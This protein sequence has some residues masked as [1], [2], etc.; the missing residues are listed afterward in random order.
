MIMEIENES[1]AQKEK[2]RNAAN[3]LLNSCFL[4]K[5]KDSTRNEYMFVRQNKEEFRQYFE[6][7][8][9]E[10]IVNEEQG[11]IGIKNSF[12]TGRLQLN[13]Y[14]SIML[15]IFR[16]L[17]VEKRRQLGTFSEEVTVLMEEVREKYSM[18]KIRSKPVMDKAMEKNIIAFF[19][20]YNIILNVD[21]DVTQAEARIIIYPSVLLAVP[22]DDINKYYTISAE[23]LMTYSKDTDDGDAEE[24]TDESQAD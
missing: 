18:L 24:N 19:R 17:Y 12:G 11:V 14:E 16:L 9:Y 13:K 7:L 22:T 10:L 15:L 6:L 21:A 1:A 20:R 4:V 8:G 23:K 5:K 3:V 2:F